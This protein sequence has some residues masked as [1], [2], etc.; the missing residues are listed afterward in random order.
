MNTVLNKTL[1]KLN[2]VV[3]PTI[4]TAS[5]SL[6]LGGGIH[7]NA[8]EQTIQLDI[9]SMNCA[10][11]PFTIKKSLSAVDGVIEIDTSLDDRL[12]TVEFDDELTTIEDLILATTNAGYPSFELDES[13]KR[14]EKE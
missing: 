14:V 2:P 1:K 13:G 5:L 8:E 9:P 12:A 6:L 11:C 10:L 7:A 4:M 3:R